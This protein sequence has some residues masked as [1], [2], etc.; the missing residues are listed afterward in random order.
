MCAPG[1]GGMAS[2]RLLRAWGREWAKRECRRHL[3]DCFSPPQPAESPSEPSLKRTVSRCA[4][5]MVLTVLSG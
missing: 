2:Y 5:V 3:A 4:G 1:S